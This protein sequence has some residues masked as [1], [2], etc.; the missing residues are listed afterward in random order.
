ME[1]KPTL[2]SIRQQ[3]T[4]ITTEQL[5]E[6]AGMS[7][8]QTYTV[9]IGGFTTKDTAVQVLAAFRRLSGKAYT[10]DEIRFQNTPPIQAPQKQMTH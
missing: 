8:G 5:A 4:H 3:H 1:R 2:L 6:E 9:E 10:L 7:L